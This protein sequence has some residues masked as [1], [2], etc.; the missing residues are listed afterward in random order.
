MRCWEGLDV[1]WLENDDEQR[2]EATARRAKTGSGHG[3]NEDRAWTWQR[4][5]TKRRGQLRRLL[6]LLR[7]GLGQRT[8][9]RPASRSLPPRH[10]PQPAPSRR[11]GDHSVSFIPPSSPLYVLSSLLKG[12]G[13]RMIRL[14]FSLSPRAQATSSATDL[15]RSSRCLGTQMQPLS[16]SSTF[17]CC[18]QAPSMEPQLRLSTSVRCTRA[19][20][21]PEPDITCRSRR[22]RRLRPSFRR[23][24]FPLGSQYLQPSPTDP[25]PR[26][27]SPRQFCG[28]HAPALHDHA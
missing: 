9:R 12:A 27:P 16:P 15:S 23:E 11:P 19:C 20:A 13:F 10:P 2:R 6:A 21:S 5:C 14:C 18:S 3:E 22:P 1:I 17:S 4:Q 25:W 7:T 26:Y 8:T 24:Y 28:S